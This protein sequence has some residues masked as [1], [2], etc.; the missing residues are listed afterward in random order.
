MDN[1]EALLLFNK[2]YALQAS[3]RSSLGGN[4]PK[5][6]SVVSTYK[7]E[8]KTTISAY[9]A[10][11]LSKSGHKVAIIDSNLRSPGLHIF[12]KKPVG[13]GLSDVLLGKAEL[14]DI[15]YDIGG[16]HLFPN[17]SIVADPIPLIDS[18]RM[19]DIIDEIKRQYDIVI[20]DTPALHDF[21][22]GMVISNYSEYVIYVIGYGESSKDEARECN[23]LLGN[24]NVGIV[25]NKVED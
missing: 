9:L 24:K 16:S 22:D 4:L 1:K 2:C 14:K 3:L 12:F 6:I 25:F 10:L 19:K 17:S 21:A 7:G 8:G 15:G 20:F 11:N 13:L 18:N 23:K 5:T